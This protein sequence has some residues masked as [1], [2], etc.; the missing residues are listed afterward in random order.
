MTKFAYYEEDNAD[1]SLE[2]SG[3]GKKP[4]VQPQIYLGMQIHSFRRDAIAAA[5][6]I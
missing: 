3:F 1:V 2:R 4:A 5:K 6:Q